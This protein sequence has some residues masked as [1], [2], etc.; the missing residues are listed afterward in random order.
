[1]LKLQEFYSI[2][3]FLTVDVERSKKLLKPIEFKLLKV[4]LSVTDFCVYKFHQK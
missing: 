3:I 1:M 2:F 4:I